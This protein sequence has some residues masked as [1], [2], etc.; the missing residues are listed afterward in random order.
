MSAA[1]AVMVRSLTDG[2]EGLMVDVSDI[3]EGEL[4]VEHILASA[5][6]GDMSKTAVLV[7]GKKVT[8]MGS[9]IA[10]G[11]EVLLIPQVANG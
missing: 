2:T 6:G 4:T 1:S 10:A 11:S 7:D 8:D 3:P 9:P 5:G